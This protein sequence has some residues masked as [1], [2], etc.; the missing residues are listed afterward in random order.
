MYGYKAAKYVERCVAY[1]MTCEVTECIRCHKTRRREVS[2]YPVHDL[3]LDRSLM[4]KLEA[5]DYVEI[6]RI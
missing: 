3:T 4:D 2:C 6:R 1:S 5:N